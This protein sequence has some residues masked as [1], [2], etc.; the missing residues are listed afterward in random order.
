MI[1]RVIKDPS[2]RR[3]SRTR[4][5]AALPQ[6]GWR[7]VGVASIGLGAGLYSADVPFVILALACVPALIAMAVITV[8]GTMASVISEV[9]QDEH[10]LR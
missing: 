5:V 1:T 9:R 7:L 10:D 8:Q 6:P 3:Q 2:T 4:A